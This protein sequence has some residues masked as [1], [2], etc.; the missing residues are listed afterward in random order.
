MGGIRTKFPFEP[1]AACWQRADI[2]DG[3]AVGVDQH[4]AMQVKAVEFLGGIVL[5]FDQQFD[6]GVGRDFQLVGSKPAADD[7]NR[8]HRIFRMGHRR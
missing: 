7:G 1:I 5:V 3:A 2:D 6:F 4:F 8:D